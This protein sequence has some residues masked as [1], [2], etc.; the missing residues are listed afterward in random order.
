MSSIISHVYIS[1][2]LKE[3]YKL[4]DEFLYGAILPDILH[5]AIPAQRREMT[6]YLRHGILY[7]SEGDYPDIERFIIENTEI[8]PK[9]QMMQGYLAHLIEDMLWFSIYIPR[10]TI[11]KDKKTIIYKK[12][13]SVHT[14]DEFR[15][16][17]YSDY[18]IIDRYLLKKTNL[19]IEKLQKEFLEISD[20]INLKNTIKDNFKL[21]DLRNENLILISFDMLEEYINA[22]L[23]KVSIVLDKIYR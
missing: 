2:I 1:N 7:G 9:S 17:I 23:E 22:S 16:D 6:H 18:T 13:N 15:N 14:D 20:D 3:K 12:D 4:G 5:K 8:L 21:F 10:M 11:E 19:D